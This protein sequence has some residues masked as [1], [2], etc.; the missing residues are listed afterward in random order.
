MQEVLNIICD[1]TL[2]YSQQLLALARL[3]ESFD[4]SL[5]L[6][7][8]LVEA[9]KEGIIC[10]LNEGNAPYRPRYICPNYSILMEK[11]SEFLQLNPPKDLYEALNSLLI[12]YRHVPSITSFPVYLG[13]LDELLE[14][15]ILKETRENA[16]KA[17]GLFLLNIDRTLCDSFVHADLSGKDTVTARM[18]LELT[19]EMQLAIPN[20]TVKYN[21]DVTS[22]D[23]MKLCIECM[24]KTAK[25]SFANDKM[26]RSE[27][28][29]KYAIASCYNGLREG[30]GGF[31]LPRLRMYECS[32]KANDADDFID[33]VLPH[34]AAI[35]LKMM[36][37]RIAFIVEKSSFFK[38]NFLVKEHFVELDN[39]TGMF[40]MVGLAECCNHLLGIKDPN[41]GYGNNPEADALGVRIMER[42]HDIVG[43]HEA[44]Y[45][46]NFDHHYRL[47]AQVGIDSDGRENSPGARI[48]IGSEPSMPKQ[49][50]HSCLF[51]KYF[52]TG[53]GDIFKFEETW[54]NT[55]DALID[56]IKGAIKNG[57]RYFSGYLEN[58]DVVRVTGY[59]VKKS[60]LAKLDAGK[61]SLNNVSIFGKGARDCSDA[62]DRRIVGDHEGSR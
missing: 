20:L 15:F 29:D 8:E 49:I 26:F 11:G 54:V 37:D 12:M 45:A 46:A 27:W 28:G 51:H 57:M 52:E 61:Q 16:K 21:P 53:I 32:L 31:T 62:L 47:H 22:D 59:L 38:S 4:H 34:Y 25:P 2:T 13:T 40:G 35:M 17:L 7:D 5:E 24:L 44:K 60:E 48:P 56:I 10:D 9:K 14:P 19:M 6:S 58:N 18:I 43:K 30:G 33:N 39:F 42:L 1:E 23:F 50:M 41:K 55:P 3:A 36:D